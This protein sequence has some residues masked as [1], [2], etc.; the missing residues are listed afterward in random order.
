CQRVSN[1][2]QQP[3]VHR[4]EPFDHRIGAS[5]VIADSSVLRSRTAASP[6]RAGAVPSQAER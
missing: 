6:A 5:G 2:D 3:G 1:A 4:P